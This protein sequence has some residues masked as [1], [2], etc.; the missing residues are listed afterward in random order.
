MCQ[1]SLFH[2]YPRKQL[3]R[4]WKLLQKMNP[5]WKIHSWMTNPFLHSNLIDLQTILVIWSLTH[6]EGVVLRSLYFTPIIFTIPGNWTPN[7]TTILITTNHYISYPKYHPWPRLSHSLMAVCLIFTSWQTFHHAYR[8]AMHLGASC[9]L[10]LLYDPY[11][12]LMLVPCI[13][14]DSPSSYRIW[15]TYL[16][17]A[18]HGFLMYYS[19]GYL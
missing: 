2:Q 10:S 1:Y 3:L 17:Y 11:L 14:H 6:R 18:P 12:R 5:N 16:G 9:I 19:T 15:S 13:P 4:S 8:T 7:L